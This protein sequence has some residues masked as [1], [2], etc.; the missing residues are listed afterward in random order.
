[1]SLLGKAEE[2]LF[3]GAMYN[4]ITDVS[5]IK[6]GHYTDKEAAT[7]CTVILC[8]AGAVAGVDVRGSAPGTRETDLL[9]PM[10]LVEK[11]HAVLLSGGSAFGLDAAGGVMRYLEEKGIGHE[12]MV[13]KVPIVPAAII[14]D[15]NI[16]SCNIRPG[17]EQGYKA[18]LAATEKKVTEGCVG[19]G[20]GATVGKILGIER[21]TKSGLGTASCKICDDVIVAALV[22]VN[23]V[24]DVIDHKTG[25][26]LAGPRN[27]QNNGFCST[28]ELLTGGTH[29]YV[30]SPLPTNTTLGAVATNANL[31]K[32]QVN[33]LAQMAQDGIARAINPSHTMFDGDTV[34]ALSIGDRTADLTTLGTAAAEVVANAIVRA[35]QQAETLACIPA[36]K[37][38]P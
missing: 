35:V 26:I 13:A 17:I 5:G 2:A 16:G 22:V 29:N 24:G 23:A 33:K 20:T 4:A 32:E 7:G 34:F 14:F 25:K 11:V 37:D 31:N 10:N 28:V 30:R 36:M 18:C 8:E 12:T 27:E 21:A 6:V 15:L 19:A 9:R 1:M 3:L 38:I